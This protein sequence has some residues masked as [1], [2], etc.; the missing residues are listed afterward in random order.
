MF[1]SDLMQYQTQVILVVL[2]TVD[3]LEDPGLHGKIILEWIVDKWA[4]GGGQ[5]RDRWGSG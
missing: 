5:G 1:V 3:H 4:G 2:G